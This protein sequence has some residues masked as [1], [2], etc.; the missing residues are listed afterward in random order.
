MT[1]ENVF[2]KGFDGYIAS[3][4]IY[5]ISN[6]SEKYFPVSSSKLLINDQFIKE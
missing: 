5:T 6:A 2:E 3:I 1:A 4:K